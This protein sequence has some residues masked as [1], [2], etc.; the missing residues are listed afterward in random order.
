MNYLTD[1]SGNSKK[2]MN[3]NAATIKADFLDVGDIDIGSN[4]EVGDQGLV[5]NASAEGCILNGQGTENSFLSTSAT[6]IGCH[7]SGFCSSDSTI[8]VESLGSYSRG[9]SAELS[10]ITSTGFGST[11]IGVA[12]DNSLIEADSDSSI[13]MG[14]AT[15]NSEILSSGDSTYAQGISHT[16]GK[17]ESDGDA[18][19]AQ[20]F[21]EQGGQLLS[22]N[23]ASISQGYAFFGKLES[24]S[25]GSTVKGYSLLN[26]DHSISD[27]KGSFVNGRHLQ[28]N[29]NENMMLIGKNG[30]AKTGL[31]TSSDT[32]NSI[33]GDSSIQIAGG[34]FNSV[35][36]GAD[37][38]ISVILGTSVFA[39]S[40]IGGGIADFFNT[41]GADY[42]EYFEWN[43]GNELN[44]DRIG[45]F[46]QLSN[47]EKIEYAS[48]D[49]DIIGVSVSD[50]NDT[51]SIIG[52]CAYK[53]WNGANLKDTFG[54]T[55]TEVTYK[56]KLTDILI[57][58]KVNM[59]EEIDNVLENSGN[60][61]IKQDLKD[62]ELTSDDDKFDLEKCHLE[63]DDSKPIKIAIPNPEYDPSLGYVPRQGRKEWNPVGLLGKVFLKDDGTCIVGQRCST[64]SE[65]IATLGSKYFVLS[66]SSENI[67]KI[68][69]K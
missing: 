3:I 20:G 35:S 61:S 27:G 38:G 12:L 46:V 10:N 32:S 56:Y 31:I 18:S 40:P 8:G 69:V 15:N 63:I 62:C 7:A 36:A 30:I 33:Q 64:N 14:S 58:N 42:A 51:S 54:R 29:S 39:N 34:L 9:A 26:T 1:A 6:S 52:D 67:V 2:W 48:N 65:G 60:D 45:H 16:N 43:D 66:R 24:K 19:C 28:T 59:T 49:E 47:N 22:S 23:T 13:A 57:L 53:Y 50:N 11:A 17:I 68:L 41:S 5:M 55:L 25:Q 37:D 44:E 21:A 4:I